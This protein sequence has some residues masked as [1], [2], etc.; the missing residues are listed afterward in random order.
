MRRKVQAAIRCD[1]RAEVGYG[2]ASCE[3]P[4]RRDFDI[5]KQA[6]EDSGEIRTAA[7]IAMTHDQQTAGPWGSTQA[8]RRAAMT[9][10][11][12]EPMNAVA[13]PRN[14][15]SNSMAERV[16]AK[17]ESVFSWPGGRCCSKRGRARR[18]SS[19]R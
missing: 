19:R 4:G 9:E 2:S 16:H 17:H 5:R 7:H 8:V 10:R 3:K 6:L 11:M 1:R 15:C 14:D 13:Y 12:Q 18:M